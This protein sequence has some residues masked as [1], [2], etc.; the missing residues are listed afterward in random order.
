MQE[1]GSKRLQRTLSQ[2][3][4]PQNDKRNVLSMHLLDMQNLTS[5]VNLVKSSSFTFTTISCIH[6][7][8]A[9]NTLAEIF[10]YGYVQKFDILSKKFFFFIYAPQL[11]FHFA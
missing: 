1:K 6:Y 10:A 8:Q 5:H 7:E 9:V 3:N 4:C 11:H 2:S